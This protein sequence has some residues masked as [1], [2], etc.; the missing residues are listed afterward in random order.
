MPKKDGARLVSSGQEELCLC[1]GGSHDSAAGKA[2]GSHGCGVVIEGL[3][4]IQRALRH[5][6]NTLLARIGDQAVAPVY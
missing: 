2:D 4:D 1:D 6:R 5:N 3:H